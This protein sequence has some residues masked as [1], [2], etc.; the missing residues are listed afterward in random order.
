MTKR[1][2]SMYRKL[3]RSLVLAALLAA[4]GGKAEPAQ[5]FGWAGPPKLPPVPATELACPMGTRILLRIDD[6]KGPL[7]VHV[8]RYYAF[9]VSP[10]GKT[11]STTDTIVASPRG[12]TGA[13]PP[14]T[15]EL[16]PLVGADGAVVNIKTL[17][18]DQPGGGKKLRGHIA[19]D[20]LLAT[21]SDEEGA[22]YDNQYAHSY[23]IKR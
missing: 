8:D 13:R 1:P 18:E 22:Y 20:Q 14:V 23:V 17:L 21:I 7:S 16:T 2:T 9:I 3:R 10:F 4:T 11:Q 19:C 15:M 6:T 5:H 12:W